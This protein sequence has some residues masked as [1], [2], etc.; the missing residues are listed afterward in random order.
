MFDT[1][2]SLPGTS[3]GQVQDKSTG[4]KREPTRKAAIL[5]RALWFFAGHYVYSVI[6]GTSMAITFNAEASFTDV[7]L[8]VYLFLLMPPSLL[9]YMPYALLQ[10][11]IVCLANGTFLLPRQILF[12]NAP[13]GWLLFV[14]YLLLVGVFLFARV[15]RDRLIALASL[16][17]F[18]LLAC[19]GVQAFQTTLKAIISTTT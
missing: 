4:D 7:M 18:Y 11:G 19:V 17:I 14:L 16:V 9:F 2:S 5:S 15:K 8:V 10:F 1:A 12:A 3:T 13:G 6:L